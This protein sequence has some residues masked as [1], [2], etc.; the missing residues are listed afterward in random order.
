[1]ALSDFQRSVCRLLADS[2]LASGEQYVAGGLALNAMLAGTRV[3]RDIDLFHDTDEALAASSEADQRA[4]ARAGYAVEPG[5]RSI[6]FVEVTVR[7]TSGEVLE[8]QWVRDS[9]YRFFP[10]ILH[11]DLGLSLHPF[12][13]ATNKVLALVGRVAARDWVD[14]ITCHERV[15]PLGCLAWA[16]CGKDAGM[17]PLF[18]VE[19]AARTARYSAPEFDALEFAGERPD[20][21]VL[22]RL[23]RHALA[24]ARTM[25][26]DLPPDEVGRAVLDEHGTPFRGSARELSQA[27]ARGGIVFHA[28]AI[29]GAIPT[30]RPAFRK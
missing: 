24:E 9:A 29:R 6:G 8:V 28:G 7:H 21:A 17:S 18:I 11:E 1:M 14:I 23:W 19:E 5:R 27:V 22:G 15:S 25:I 26:D 4:L 13:L 12:D 2:R 20:R 10:L 3:S 16:A 30:V